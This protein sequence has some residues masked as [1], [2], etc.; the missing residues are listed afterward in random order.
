MAKGE[1]ANL[2]DLSEA[3]KSMPQYKDLLS[4]YSMHIDLAK[5]CMARYE[6]LHLELVATQEQ[7]MAMKA[8]VQG[9]P[10]KMETALQGVEN[11]LHRSDISDEAKLRLILIFVISQEGVEQGQIDRLILA[12]SLKDPYAAKKAVANLA[13]LHVKK[14]KPPEPPKSMKDKSMD[15]MAKLFP[16]VKSD[17]TTTRRP[18][19]VFVISHFISRA[20]AR[21]HTLTLMSA[22]WHAGGQ[23]SGGYRDGR[24]DAMC[25]WCGVV[26]CGVCVCGWVRVVC[27]R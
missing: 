17:L 9:A 10:V 20:C 2:K 5:T 16:F 23:V 24:Q 21:T 13:H 26:W 25:V 27:V 18:K 6:E 15:Q 22:R 3:I 7:N 11:V 1:A 8:D 4:K 14:E 19:Q 12:A